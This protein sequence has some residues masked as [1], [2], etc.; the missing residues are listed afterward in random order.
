MENLGKLSKQNT[1]IPAENKSLRS[2]SISLASRM[3]DT[4]RR[5]IKLENDISMIMAT[6]NQPKPNKEDIT[7]R[8]TLRKMNSRRN[9]TETPPGKTNYH[10]KKTQKDT[11][12]Q[13]QAKDTEELKENPP[14]VSWAAIARSHRTQQNMLP[15]Y[16][17]NRIQRSRELL[18]ASKL[19]TTRQ[20]DPTA[21]Y[22][23]S[24]RRGPIGS[25]RRALRQSLPSWALLVIS[26]VGGSVLEIVTDIQLE[27]RLT[28]TLKLMGIEQIRKFDL[29]GQGKRNKSGMDDHTGSNHNERM[30]IRRMK[31][32]INTSRS[33]QARYWYRKQ[34]D[35][36]K[37]KLLQTN[38]KSKKAKKGRKKQ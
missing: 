21:V 25:I 7:E 14:P 38:K 19:R 30:V 12:S 18:D 15:E 17:T 16:L 26:F 13:T 10:D 23:K 27:E 5:V 22:F 3:E 35:K 24:I 1:Y 31:A 32:C 9:E 4:Q 20:P 36:E 2:E 34:L 8:D 33:A 28:A 29:H 37:E 6:T 11:T